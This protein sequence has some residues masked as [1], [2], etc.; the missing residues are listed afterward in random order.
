MRVNLLL[1]LLIFSTFA[2]SQS[3][4]QEQLKFFDKFNTSDAKFW[5]SYWHH[6]K[7][8]FS[9]ADTCQLK[10]LVFGWHPY[11]S[12]GLEDN[13]Q[14][15]LLSDL[16]Y[17]S[18]EV[19]YQTGRP[20]DMHGW[21]TAAVVD[22]AKRHN[23]RVHLTATLFSNHD[24]F[25][26][27][28]AAQDTLINRLVEAVQARGADGINIDFEGMGSD[29]RTQFTNFISKLKQRMRQVNSSLILSIAL[30]AVDW[31]NVFDIPSLVANVDLFIIMGYDYYWSGSSEA[32]PVGQLY[33]LNNFNYTE[34]R[35]IVYYLHAGVPSNRLLLGVPYYGR[36][37]QTQSNAVPSA[38][39]SYS[40]VVLVKNFYNTY[41]NPKLDLTSRSQYVAYNSSGNWYQV[42]VDAD[43]AMGYKYQVVKQTG[44]AGIGI[45]ALGYDDGRQEMWEE[46]RKFFTNCKFHVMDTLWDLGGPERNYWNNENYGFVVDA[47]SL[48]FDYVDMESGYDYLK[49]YDGDSP[50][51]TLL[52][53][54]S[55]SFTNQVFAS[56]TGKFYLKV[57]TDGATVK[58]GWEAKIIK[59]K[60]EQNQPPVQV[61]E[62]YTG[63]YPNPVH[64]VLK[65]RN[66]AT[67]R[68]YII[69]NLRGQRV[70]DGFYNGQINM[71]GLPGGIYILTYFSDKK[72][73]QKFIKL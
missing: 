30:P 59:S 18:Y 34:S 42:W 52:A 58:R 21:F 8:K 61:E 5:A 25:F 51:G 45:W 49:I 4:H 36:K 28:Q 63:V 32:G 10:N 13:Y 12:N 1:A 39:V 57:E 2:Y 14:W 70:K 23:V 47:D 66:V 55:G 46:I 17:F 15:N 29:N 62:V 43:S 54:L 20:V 24:E 64:D 9:K 38:T 7:V 27:S 31:S 40:G 68:F 44:I 73:V 19:D 48:I 26:G 6:K 56:S 37:W 33:V 60:S 65:L 3:I 50:E 11:W 53:S 72:L 67:G 71:K 41:S 35:S 16:A 22:S 69:R